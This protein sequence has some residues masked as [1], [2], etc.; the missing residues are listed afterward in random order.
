[1]AVEDSMTRTSAR[2]SA[3]FVPL[4]LASTACTTPR[5]TPPADQDSQPMDRY[6]SDYGSP[7]P[8]APPEL[9]RFAFLIGSWRC[10]ARLK[11]ED[12]SWEPLEA[13]WVGRYV[14][15]GYAIMDEFRMTRPTGEL[16]VLGANLRAYDVK[17]EAWTLKWLNALDGTWVDLGPEELGGVQI[18]GHSISYAFEEPV[19][20]HAL[21]RA[22][23]LDISP[24][25]FTWRGERSSDGKAW[26]EFLV[27][28]AHRSS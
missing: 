22:T 11:G 27:I 26:E 12:G 18:D 7:N 20:P 5:E 24:N 15:D 8:N 9:S 13:S 1:M 3:V 25:H 21:T 2:V 4:V 6:Q 23:Y 28:E 19:G 10:D 16:L 17:N 14:L